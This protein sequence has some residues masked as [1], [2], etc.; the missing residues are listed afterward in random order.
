MDGILGYLKEQTELSIF[1]TGNQTLRGST[2]PCIRL[3]SLWKDIVD[4][5]VQ[6]KKIM[7]TQLCLFEFSIIWKP[8]WNLEIVCFK[9]SP[10]MRLI[11]RVFEEV[12][13]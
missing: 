12:S 1:E 10:C 11:G 5:F 4:Q 3:H 9:T 2:T 6:W 13:V 7:D 8:L